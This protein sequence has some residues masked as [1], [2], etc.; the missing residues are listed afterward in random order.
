MN[1]RAGVS[2]FSG[3]FESAADAA[4]FDESALG[5]DLSYRKRLGGGRR[6]DIQGEYILGRYETAGE[7][8]EPRGFYLYASYVLVPG[9]QAGLRFDSFEPDGNS[10]RTV[11]RK[12]TTLATTYHI[13]DRQQIDVNYEIVSDDLKQADNTLTAQFQIAF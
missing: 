12:R 5:V 6:L 1:I 9:F 11:E 4:G 8:L 10:A 7:D 3:T 2:Y 13:R